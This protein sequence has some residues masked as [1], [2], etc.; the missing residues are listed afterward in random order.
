M[1]DKIIPNIVGADIFCNMAM[2]YLG[3]LG[4]SVE[5]WLAFDPVVREKIPMAFKHR[6]KPVMNIERD[7]PWAL[8]NTSAHVFTRIHY[9]INIQPIFVNLCL[10]DSASGQ[11]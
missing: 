2:V 3:K 7:F 11:A 9:N 8:A 1:E 5:E 10:E 4:Y 6:S